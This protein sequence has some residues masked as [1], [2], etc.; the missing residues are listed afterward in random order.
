M[1]G[2]CPPRGVF[3]RYGAVIDPP[4]VFVRYREIIDP[5]GGISKIWG[6]NCPPPLRGSL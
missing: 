2:Y 4:G 6:D 3:V 5:P 1:G